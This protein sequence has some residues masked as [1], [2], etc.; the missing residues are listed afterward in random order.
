VHKP[1]GLQLLKNF[2]DDTPR[3]ALTM[4]L[5]SLQNRV[6]DHL[7][8]QEQSPLI[9]MERSIYSGYYCF[10][11][12][13][14]EQGFLDP[15]EWY[16]YNS[17]FQFITGQKCKVPQGFIY[18]QADPEVSYT[19]TLHRTRNAEQNLSK[20]YLEQIHVKHEEFLIQKKE[21]L[22]ELESVPTLVLDCNNDFKDNSK[23][24][25]QHLDALQDFFHAYGH[26]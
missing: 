1:T 5:Q 9:V 8:Q 24:L 3:W 22:P 23:V 4:E 10:A 25:T 20:A 18:L 7:Y 6:K 15:M 12:N 17:W 2:Y 14:Y 16:I 19:R 26:Q 21:I 13:G 11:K